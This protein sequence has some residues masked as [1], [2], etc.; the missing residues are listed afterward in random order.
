MTMAAIGPTRPMRDG[1]ALWLAAAELSA[2]R[3]CRVE[4]TVVGG[5]CGAHAANATTPALPEDNAVR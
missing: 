2:P 1:T 4:P 3:C 5:L